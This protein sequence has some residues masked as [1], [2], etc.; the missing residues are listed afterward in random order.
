MVLLGNLFDRRVVAH[1]LVHPVPVPLYFEI[2]SDL[3]LLY[4][5]DIHST[6]LTKTRNEPFLNATII[7]SNYYGNHYLEVTNN[8]VMINL[9]AFQRLDK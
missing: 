5:Y 8:T 6:I 4:G 3:S 1:Q 9:S 7:S 2:D